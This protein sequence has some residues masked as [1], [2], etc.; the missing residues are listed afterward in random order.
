VIRCF[1]PRSAVLKHIMET[2]LVQIDETES[3]MLELPPEIGS[4]DGNSYPVQTERS[5]FLNSIL[6]P[7]RVKQRSRLKDTKMR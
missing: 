4:V 5:T 7:Q 6:Y 1:F 2:D 3:A